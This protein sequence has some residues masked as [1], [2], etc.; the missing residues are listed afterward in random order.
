[1]MAAAAAACT[2]LFFDAWQVANTRYPLRALR[3][4]SPVGGE[5]GRSDESEGKRGRAQ[6]DQPA[7]LWLH[8]GEGEERS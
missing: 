8:A 3:R 7:R 5:A 2:E 6:A 1:M 4:A